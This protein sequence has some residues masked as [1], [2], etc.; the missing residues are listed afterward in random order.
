MLV[1]V[2]GCSCPSTFS[3][4][5]S[6]CLCIASASSCLPWLLSTSAKLF[7]LFLLTFGRSITAS[8]HAQLSKAFPGSTTSS[9]RNRL[10]ALRAEMRKLHESLEYEVPGVSGKK[11]SATPDKK[12]S[13]FLKRGR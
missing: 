6:V 5:A 2:S 7:K 4:R 3:L 8:E 10:G 12:S 9:I 13:A 1:S 11:V